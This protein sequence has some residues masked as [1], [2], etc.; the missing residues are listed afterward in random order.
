MQRQTAK[1]MRI[2]DL[3]SGE[4]I[5]KE[6][7]EPSYVVTPGK[8]NV[9]RAM[10]VGTVVNKFTSEDGNFSS[11]TI[12]DSTATMRAK[13]WKEIGLLQEIN[14]GDLVRVIGKVRE[15][16]GEIY[17]VPE[18]M[19]KITPDEESLFRLEIL[20]QMKNRGTAP[21]KAPAKSP[22]IPAAQEQPVQ[23]KPE[24]KP[25]PSKSPAV[26]Q[27]EPTL[28][29][30]PEEPTEPQPEPTPPAEEKPAQP[31]PELKPAAAPGEEE[32]LRVKVLKV[33]EQNPEGIKYSD[34]LTQLGAPE[35]D[36]ED[37]V[38]ELLGEGVCYEPM[39]GKIKKI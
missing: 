33:I 9:S 23:P 39:P 35:E 32:N 6:G 14:T 26:P 29:T 15:Y 17:V 30:V 36:M 22:A 18:I 10:S 12:D 38:N 8:E 11:V 2:V 28:T 13:L 5:K 31:E 27:E 25:I 20:N 21:V 37:V 1:M 16:E 7:M 3:V 19:R 34:L 24:P 4:F